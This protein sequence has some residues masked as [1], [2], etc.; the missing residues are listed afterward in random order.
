MG[1]PEPS[2]LRVHKTLKEIIRYASTL[3]QK[4]YRNS[5][6]GFEL[7]VLTAVYVRRAADMLE[8]NEL[9]IEEEKGELCLGK[10]VF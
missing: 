1:K 7:R 8:D 5:L 9:D 10:M 4:D 2:R 3:A 6:D